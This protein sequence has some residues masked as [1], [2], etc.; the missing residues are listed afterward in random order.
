MKVLVLGDIITDKYIYGSSSRIS[1]EAPVPVVNITSSATSLGGAGLVF[2]NLKSLGVDVTLFDTMQP[3]ST[4]TRIISDGHYITRLD[5]DEQ[6]DGEVVLKKVIETDFS[7]Y[8]YVIL[9]DY[10]KGVLDDAKQIIK[11]INSQGC[12]V[13]VDPKRNAKFYQDARATLQVK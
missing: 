10:N 6:A 5:E 7:Q 2:E 12:K 4:K 9:S 11:H 1:P 13:I 3:R 8:E